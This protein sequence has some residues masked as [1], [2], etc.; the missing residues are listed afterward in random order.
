M[1]QHHTIEI[2]SA[3]C[4][5]CRHIIDDIEIGK[6][7]GCSTTIYNIRNM[8]EEIEV[9]MRNYDITSVPTVI[10]DGSIKVVGIPDFPWICGE[11]LYRK[12][13]SKYSIKNNH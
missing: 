8:T 12:L 6:C 7:E 11:D 9:K 3:D 10:I 1:K 5:L 4:P 13:K 2:F